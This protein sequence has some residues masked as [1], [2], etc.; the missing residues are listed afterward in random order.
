MDETV[1]N[2]WNG[3]VFDIPKSIFTTFFLWLFNLIRDETKTNI[4]KIANKK[5]MNLR[6][7]KKK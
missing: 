7:K 4:K 2:L 3:I 1:T 5:I 6:T